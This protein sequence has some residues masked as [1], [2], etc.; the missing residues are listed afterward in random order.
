MLLTLAMT[1]KQENSPYVS[2]K[3][4]PY[5][6]VRPLDVFICVSIRAMYYSINQVLYTD[7]LL[8]S[9]QRMATNAKGQW[10]H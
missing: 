5:E 7:K 6:R 10:H 1:S 3:F 2:A 8:G 9:T 4:V